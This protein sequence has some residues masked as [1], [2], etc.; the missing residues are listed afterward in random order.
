VLQKITINVL[1]LF[2]FSFL[3][4]R[5]TEPSTPCMHAWTAYQTRG[6]QRCEQEQ[7]CG[8]LVKDNNKTSTG[9]LLHEWEPAPSRDSG[10]LL[11]H[12]RLGVSACTSRALVPVTGSDGPAGLRCQH[13]KALDPRCCS[14]ASA[15]SEHVILCLSNSD[16]NQ[17]G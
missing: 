4:H 13:L 5:I 16:C 1:V 15:T 10:A 9:Q 17:N 6:E 12:A 11:V 8:M 7:H 14:S 2:F 3:L